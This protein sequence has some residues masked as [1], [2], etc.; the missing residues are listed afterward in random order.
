MVSD[1]VLKRLCKPVVLRR[2]QRIVATGTLISKRTCRFEEGET[3]LKARVDSSSSWDEAH[4]TSAV[5]D[6]VEDALVYYECD[7]HS[8]HATDGPCDHVAALVMDYNRHPEGFDG[9]GNK[10]GPL[11]SRGIARLIERGAA[12]Q[13][14]LPGATP[15]DVHPGSVS[16][17]P[18]LSYEVGFDVR[19]RVSGPGGTYA[20]RSISEFVFAVE[21][22]D[23]FAYG[24]R[25]AFE[26]KLPMFTSQSQRLTEFIVRAVQ[27]RR[28]YAFERV[29]G[30][31]TSVT[32]SSPLR[33]LHLSAPELW[34]LLDIC[35]ST[36]ILFDDRTTGASAPVA[37]KMRIVRHDPDIRLGI[38][39][40]ESG[41]F[42]VERV[43]G[44]HLVA[45]GQHALAWDDDTLYCCSRRLS[46]DAS[47]LVPL[48]GDPSEHM[49]LSDKD[50]SA[51]CATVLPRLEE[52][53]RLSVTPALDA[54]RPQPC[55]LRFYV[56]YRPRES[57]VTCDARAAY[58]DVV[59]SLFAMRPVAEVPVGLVRDTRAE[60]AG[61]EAVR[62][63][64][65]V[66]DGV[67]TARAK[68]ER[69]GALVYEGV[70]ALQEVGV[71]YVAPAF[72][73]LRSSAR[74]QIRVGLSVRSNLLD[75][76]F[77]LTGLPVEELAGLLE[78]YT[79]RSVYH[80]LRD[81]S[82]VRMED[83]DI[84]VAGRVV[85]ELGLD[86]SRTREVV[87]MPAYRALMLEGLVEDEDKDESLQTYLDGIHAVD[88]ASYVVPP[89]L[90]D[91]LRPYQVE[92][93]KWLCRLCDLGLGGIL[94]DEMGLGKSLQLISFLLARAN[95]ARE[96][97]PSLVVCP[98][99]LVYNWL[100][101]FNK[102]APQLDVRVIAGTP[103]ERAEVRRQRDADVL[104]TS[105]DLLRRDVQDYEDARLWC[106][107]LDE[108]QY[109]KN[110][111]TQ[112][113]RAVK[114]LRARFRVA[115]TGTPVE[116]RLSELWSIFDFLMPG[117]LG[118]YDKFRERYERPIV[119]D[120]DAQ[121]VGRLREAVRPFILRRAKA[122][123]AQDLPEKIEQV[124]RAH[125]GTR[126]R[127][128]YDAQVQEVRN[129]VARDDDGSFGSQ[130]FQVLALLTRLRQVCCDPRL[131]YEDYAD[132]SCK[133]ETIITLV[134]R[135]VDAGEKMLLFSQFTSYLDVLAAELGRRGIPFYTIV[136]STPSSRRVE[137]VNKFND[138][139][140]P[141]FLISLK[142]GGTGLNLTGATVVVHADPWWNVAAQNQ[143]TDRAHR[144]GQ[145]REVTVYEVIA[146]GTIEER[147]LELQRT[148]AELADAVVQGDVSSLSLS[149]LTRE[150]L[151][152]LLA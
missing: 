56:D 97:G 5:L 120:E 146:A 91:V 83:A 147:I 108:A 149:S 44:V 121:T 53:V 107:A 111:A 104:I 98:S 89:S 90:S 46:N 115:L 132:A 35:A 82:F 47:L 124:V 85:E 43:R 49:V 87:S 67:A 11:T 13:S 79:R 80:R 51:F 81:G 17:E 74:P 134:E 38:V 3:V 62:R 24:K 70:A 40:L 130:K 7:C 129:Q 39:A 54:Y 95:K 135:V 113:A 106:V 22:G 4:R 101:E 94:A 99:S 119:E 68:G 6:E 20:L 150:D 86:A 59:L 30:R 14:S 152:E 110:P 73:R 58:G 57:L 63:F 143:A 61:R 136:G 137:L 141:V 45:A 1:T 109:I 123:V 76:S 133:T 2:A 151:E 26:H 84:D 103:Q 27:N 8:S 19:F 71:V 60:S 128:L 140:T 48:L 41:G 37:Q 127:M 131:L 93:F 42:E 114:A 29:T 72:E 16:L 28:A 65:E 31:G 18:T 78:S 105:Y 148:K 55:E 96:V 102:F 9:Y 66:R 12:A 142:A 34:D 77:G 145:T 116:N 69:L 138:D 139:D 36:G 144:I 88:D 23:V 15:T 25:L 118:S 126:Q 117:L 33:E 125:M 21:S 122:D 50:A 75:L 100:A 92:G 64:F 52:S 10:N 112:S 32:S